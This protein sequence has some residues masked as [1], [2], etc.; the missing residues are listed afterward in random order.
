MDLKN[1]LYL[2]AKDLHLDIDRRDYGVY[3]GFSCKRFAFGG[4]MKK[5]LSSIT[6]LLLLVGCNQSSN[7]SL[8]VVTSVYPAYD[9]AV[10]MVGDSGNVTNIVPSG[11]DAHSFEPTPQDIAKIQ[12]SDLFVYHGSGLETWVDAVLKTI[13]SSK[14]KLVS[15]SEHSNLIPVEDTHD[16]HDHDDHEEHDDHDGHKHG[17]F[18]VHSWLS[19]ENA[20]SQMNAIKES[21]VEIDPENKEAYN[22][23][24]EENSNKLDSLKAEYE[25][26]KTLGDHLDILV[27]HKAY[28]YLAHDYGLHQISIIRGSLSEEPTAAELQDSIDFIKSNK[29]ESIYVSPNSSLK[30]YDIIKSETGVEVYPLHTLESLT[31]TEIEEGKD[32]FSV[33]HSNLES[34][35]EGLSHAGHNH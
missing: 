17:N 2:N 15:L 10:K 33:M 13:D 26:L 31:K 21:L 22:Q 19:I 1:T 35:K 28:G 7:D 3:N 18:D 29:I 9:F 32:Y 5:I 34:L 23:R 6:V 4:F 12:E 25:S 8:N 11:A 24:F 27:D 14:V 16:S 30:V 20:R